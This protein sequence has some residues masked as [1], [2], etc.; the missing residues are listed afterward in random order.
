MHTTVTV[1]VPGLL[2]D[3][4]GGQRQ[5]QATGATLAAALDDLLARYPLLRVH[6]FEENGRLRPHVLIFLN[7]DNI[8]WLDSSAT[9]LKPGDELHILQAVSGG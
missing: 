8:A 6:L 3:S 1:N 5:V 7:G 2:R 9:P 4:V